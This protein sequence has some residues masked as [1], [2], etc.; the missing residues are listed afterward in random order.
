MRKDKW[1]IEQLID[2]GAYKIEKSLASAALND[3]ARRT[4]DRMLPEDFPI[5]DG[6]LID[7]LVQHMTNNSSMQ[8]YLD[9]S[10]FPMKKLK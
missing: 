5:Q 2:D 4:G 3:V 1:S 7:N 8:K 9:K 10:P 6:Q